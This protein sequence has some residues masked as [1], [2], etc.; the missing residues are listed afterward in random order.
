MVDLEVMSRGWCGTVGPMCAP[1]DQT[2]LQNRAVETFTTDNRHRVTAGQEVYLGMRG[3]AGPFG[4]RGCGQPRLL[5][6]LPKCCEWSQPIP[7]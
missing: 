5:D 7:A 3:W 4:S 6:R 2:S 1:E